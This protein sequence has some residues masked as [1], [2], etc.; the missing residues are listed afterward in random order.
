MT[1]AKFVVKWSDGDLG[2]FQEFASIASTTAP[3]AVYG[4]SCSLFT[5]VNP[6][7][8]RLSGSVFRVLQASVLV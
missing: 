6:T 7:P 2:R 1:G 5:D 4:G 3:L 8:F